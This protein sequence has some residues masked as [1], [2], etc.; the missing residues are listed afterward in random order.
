MEKLIY[1][2]LNET[3][4][5]EILP[6]GLTAYYLPKVNYHKTYGIFTTTF[7][8]LDVMFNGKAYPEGIAHFLEHKLFEKKEGDVMYKF[9][10][11]GA[12]TNAFTSFNRTAYLFYTSEHAKE[13]VQLLLN[14]VQQPYF[15]KE[16]VIKE[17]GI[18]TQEIQMYQDDPDW[19]LYAGVLAS[20]YPNSPLAD[21]IAGTPQSISEITAEM[22]YENH[23]A[24]Y[25]PK[26]MSFFVTGPFDSDKMAALVEENQKT[27]TTFDEIPVRAKF[28][29][30]SAINQSYE[31]M[32]VVMPKVALGLRGEDN[33]VSDEIMEYNLTMQLFLA[34]VFGKTS[35][36]YENAYQEGLI[37]DSFSYEFEVESRF[38]CLIFSLDTENPEKFSEALQEV[39]KNY[40]M[41]G[42]IT[43]DRLELMK[44]QMLGRHYA[45][46]N[47]L[48]WIANEFA[49]L[50]VSSNKT[51]FDLP[52]LLLSLTV[53]KVCKVAER[54]LKTAEVSQHII[55]PK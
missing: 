52:N 55:Y 13:S 2:N 48:E 10:A 53:E 41:K 6:N 44:R 42:G 16:N 26:N 17:R 22:L 36:F 8:S 4:Y 21:D 31:K 39:L 50:S 14:F 25:Q 46:L 34:I 49:T 30:S 40:K 5:K 45:S 1:E 23:A 37:D 3:L 28:L 11:L 51:I 15:T 19:R 7:G 33:V 20:M 18:I 32:D 9:G 24:F 29:P 38:H 54:F 12:Q 27:V 35:L 43:S 47:S